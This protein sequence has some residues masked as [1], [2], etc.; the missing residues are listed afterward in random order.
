MAH[1]MEKKISFKNMKVLVAGLA[2]SGTGAANLLSLLGADVTIIDRKSGSSLKA[3]IDRLNPSIKVITGE[4]P[5][6]IFTGSDLIVVSPGIPL[7]IP[8]IV[9]ARVQGAL[10]IGELE[11]A[12]RVVMG[13]A[14]VLLPIANSPFPIPHSPSPVFIGITGTNGKSTV[15]TLVNLMMRRSGFRTLL[16]GNIGNA[17]TEELFKMISGGEEISIDHIVAEISSFQLESIEEFRPKVAAILNI[18]P[19]HLDRYSNIEEYIDAK[20]RIFENQQAGDFLILNADDPVLMQMGTE[21]LEVRSEKP[22]TLYFSRQGEVEGI[23]FKDGMIYANSPCFPFPT[24]HLPLLSQ[25]ELKIKGLHNLENAMAA[26]AVALA[27]GCS[28]EAVADVLK[29]FPGLEHRMEF[30]EEFNGVRFINDSKGTNVGAV[31]KSLESFNKVV[32]IMGGLDK[33]GDF[34]G[35]RSLITEKVRA[36]ILL[37]RAKEKISDALGDITET[38]YVNDIKE[39]V[40]VSLSK[41]SP[42]DVVLLS[43]GCASFDMFADFEDRGR[44]FKEA[45]RE[46]V[47]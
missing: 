29:D 4:N 23:Y 16:G 5:E 7:N 9:K 11:L 21:K 43:P 39:A 47:K 36:L 2:R 26:S 20:L 3:N 19:D 1:E 32:L 35:L 24:S 37:G 44:K 18:T 25:D 41:A 13:S 40:K 22:K 14:P 31:V 45:V 12:Y 46:V 6:S 10:I 28:Y 15:T 42:G 17:L 33:G 34:I 38:L 8:L 30:V 27:S